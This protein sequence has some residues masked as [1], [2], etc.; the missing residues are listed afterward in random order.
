MIQIYFLLYKIIWQRYQTQSIQNLHSYNKNYA[1]VMY[2]TKG[3]TEKNK[4]QFLLEYLTNATTKGRKN[5]ILKETI[6]TLFFKM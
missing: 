6:N 5:Q 1:Y 2:R 4:E 3:S